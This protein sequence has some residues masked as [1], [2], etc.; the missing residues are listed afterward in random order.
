MKNFTL[1]RASEVEEIYDMRTKY[2]FIECID[3]RPGPEIH[4][5]IDYYFNKPECEYKRNELHERLERALDKKDYK[6][7]L[8]SVLEMHYNTD[9]GEQGENLVSYCEG[10]TN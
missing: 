4:S 8:D 3:L 6:E 10:R 5:D 9:I 2:Y 7:Y 1:K